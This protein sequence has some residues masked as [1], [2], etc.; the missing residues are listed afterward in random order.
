METKYGAEIALRQLPLE[1]GTNH[2]ALDA[3]SPTLLLDRVASK[4]AT[5][6]ST[7]LTPS[8]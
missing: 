1:A 4:L 6:L 3:T 8:F 7:V 5:S 2:L